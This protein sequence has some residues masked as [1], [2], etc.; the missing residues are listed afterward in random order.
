MDYIT[1]YLY[2]HIYTPGTICYIQFH[3][4]IQ[5]HS[6]IAAFHTL[7]FLD[8]YIHHGTITSAALS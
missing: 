8:F 1:I 5:S 2:K 3:T 4:S 7:L 6:F